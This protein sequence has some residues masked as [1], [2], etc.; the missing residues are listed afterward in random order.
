[1]VGTDFGW[2]SRYWQDLGAPWGGMFSTPADFAVVLHLLLNGGAVGG[3]RIAW[4]DQLAGARQLLRLGQQS[5]ELRTVVRH[6]T[7]GDL[8]RQRSGQRR[9]A[10]S[11][12]PTLRR[13]SSWCA[14]SSALMGV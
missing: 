12:S 6:P 7:G 3:V 13:E 14:S 4:F 8:G 10:A 11:S 5:G 9:G 2:N 1:M